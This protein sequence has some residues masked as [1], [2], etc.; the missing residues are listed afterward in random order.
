MSSAWYW[1]D[2]DPDAEDNGDDCDGTEDCICR[3]CISEEE[4]RRV[5]AGESM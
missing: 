2:W 5:E 4:L 1:P 3:T